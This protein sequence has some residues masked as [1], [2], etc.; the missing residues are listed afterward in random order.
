MKVCHTLITLFNLALW[1]KDKTSAPTRT[2]QWLEERCRLFEQW[3][4]P[5]VIAQKGPEFRWLVMFD[6]DTPADVRQ[7]IRQWQ[8][9]CPALE[10]HFFTAAEVDGF[11]GTS[12]G[13]RV[14]FIN[15]AIRSCLDG[16]EEWLLT[17]NLDNDD[18][19]A[20]DAMLRIREAFL[21][22]PSQRIISLVDGLQ[23]FPR[24]GAAMGMIY[25]HNHFL[26]LCEPLRARCD[27]MTIESLSHREARRRFDVT[28]LRGRVG[29]IEVVHD[30]NISNDLRITS[31]IAYRPLLRPVDLSPFG[32]SRTISAGNQLK[33]TAA[34]SL[35]FFKVA[36]R[37]LRRKLLKPHA[38]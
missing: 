10:P 26:T 37:R 29:W 7:R 2:R 14:D 3:C 11:A 30:N 19:L 4:L 13:R 25:P 8:H 32:I 23:M 12:T 24:F 17:T 5:S 21:S 6:A 20:S 38:R 36:L 33:G 34:I 9:L 27:A 28:D 35:Y 15:R 22:N 31:R 1:S 16:D 18:A